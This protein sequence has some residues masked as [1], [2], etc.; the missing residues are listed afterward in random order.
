M[1]EPVSFEQHTAID[2]PAAQVCRDL[3]DMRRLRAAL[4]GGGRFLDPRH[5]GPWSGVGGRLAARVEHLGIKRSGMWVLESAPQAGAVGDVVM[6]GEF[7]PVD[8][9]LTFEVTPTDDH[10]AQVRLVAEA[11]PQPL[12]PWRLA[13]RRRLRALPE[14]APRVLGEL[15][16]RLKEEIEAQPLDEAFRP[17]VTTDGY[18]EGP[19]IGAL[20][21]GSAQTA[22][23]LGRSVALFNVEGKV[24][25]MAASCPHAGAPLAEGR[26]EGGVVTCPRHGRRYDLITGRDVD[27]A[28]AS[29]PVYPARVQDG[30]VWVR[31]QLV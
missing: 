3:A 2:R 24:F 23:F 21:P 31:I 10:R 25:A 28:T 16:S 30:R 4:G 18:V 19:A 5:Y 17:V 12:F 22:T 13:T 29:V 15:L 9:L 6:R 11:R 27:R 20:P 1:P 14:E 26:V 7:P 8:Y